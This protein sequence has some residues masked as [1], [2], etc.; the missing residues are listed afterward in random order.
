METRCEVIGWLLVDDDRAQMLVREENGRI[1]QQAASP[2]STFGHAIQTGVFRRGAAI[3]DP[4]THETLGYEMETVSS[5][6]A[7]LA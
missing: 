1:S 3:V 7:A 6:V 4:V 5:L 2:E